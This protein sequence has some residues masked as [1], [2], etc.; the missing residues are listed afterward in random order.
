ME[1]PV[2]PARRKPAVRKKAATR[3]KQEF[4]PT[5]AAVT[6]LRKRFGMNVAQ[7][8]KLVGVS[9]PTVSNWENGSGKL[10]LRQRNLNALI[11]A[12]ELTPE[13]AQREVGSAR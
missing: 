11:K 1:E 7:F 9:P 6:R 5:A 8:A 2:K 10:N 4:K 3:N 12:A 13:Q